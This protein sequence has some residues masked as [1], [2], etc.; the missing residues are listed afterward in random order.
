M[1]ITSKTAILSAILTAML[2]CHPCPAHAQD[3]LRRPRVGVVLSGGGAKGMAHIGVMKV[4]ERAGI[5]VDIIVGTSMGSIVG[6]LYSCGW[7]SAALDSIVR[8]QDWAFLLS[9]KDDYYSQNLINREKQNTYL[10]SRSFTPGRQSL[11]ETGG[12]IRG[13]NLEKLFSTLTSGYNDSIGFDSLPIPFSCVATNIIDNTEYD[14]HSGVLA[15]AMRASMSIPGVFAPIRRGKMV[16]V[17]G[18]LRNNFPADIARQMGADVIIG[19]TVQ[20][21]PKSADDLVTGAAVLGQIIDVNCKN[22]YDENLAITDLPIRVNTVG[23]GSASFTPAA[24][25]TLIRRGEEEATRHWHRLL[26]LKQQIGLPLDSMPAYRN[27]R[28]EAT[29]PVDFSL[30][31]DPA[32]PTHDRI[33]GNLGVRFDTED[34]VALQLNGVYSSA[35]KP[36]DLEATLRLGRNIMA[37]AAARWKPKKFVEMSL[38][39]TFRHTGINIYEQG[40]NVW[41]VTTNQHQACLSFLNIS[42]K[43]LSMDIS[44]RADFYDYP[45][46]LVSSRGEHPMVNIAHEH[47]ISYH[48]NLH[49]NSEDDWTFPTRGAQ[50]RGEYAYFTDNFINYLGHAGFR[51]LSASWQ[52]SFALTPPLTVQPQ[53]YGRM[54]WGDNRPIIRH[55][56]IGGQWAGHYIEQQMPFAGVYHIEL[57]DDKMVACQLKLQEQLTTNNF[58]ILRLAAAQQANLTGDLLRHAPLLGAQMTYSYRTL[59]GPVSAALGYSNKSRE[60]SL[61]ISLGFVF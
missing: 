46:M 31:H 60:V 45:K 18:G 13:R 39:Y 29:R 53:L 49:Y 26:Q 7:N 28:P 59:L 33:Q 54:L 22:K 1:T 2:W 30:P 17:D 4:I 21:P 37:T 24:I 43:N 10:I 8:K 20:G 57:V 47:F 11:H 19:V 5:P 44:A 6:G 36:L 35:R 16:L 27:P 41:S 61:L 23:Y 15:N 52:M 42:V 51:E 56:V 40:D 50:F 55:N 14:F 32:R 9:D 58:L 12:L 48:A 38:A 34:M 25:D 3:S